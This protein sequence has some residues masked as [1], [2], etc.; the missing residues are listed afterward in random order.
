MIAAVTDTHALICYLYNDPRLSMTARSIIETTVQ[1]GDQIALS[2]IR[3]VE[4]VYLIEKG[5]IPSESFSIVAAELA[6]PTSLLTEIP[7]DLTI[8]RALAGVDVS[9]VPD[10]PDRIIAATAVSLN[11]PL[12]SRDGKIRLSAVNTIW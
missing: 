10:M 11:V 6:D 1:S 12:L 3:L 9:Q 7:L 5:R 2:S 8:T 4:M